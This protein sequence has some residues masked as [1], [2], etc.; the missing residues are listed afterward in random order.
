LCFISPSI[1]GSASQVVLLRGLNVAGDARLPPFTPIKDLRT[2]NVFQ[3]WGV[4]VVRLVF[5]WE[6]YEPNR[7]SYSDGYLKYIDGVVQ[8]RILVQLSLCFLGGFFPCLR[9]GL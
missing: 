6:A 4:N 2:M 1:I 3:T 7:G 5:I 9:E 8:V